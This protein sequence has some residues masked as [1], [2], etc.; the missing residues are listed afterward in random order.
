MGEG[1]AETNNLKIYEIKSIFLQVYLMYIK[2]YCWI[3]GFIILIFLNN[4][5][6]LMSIEAFAKMNL[7]TRQVFS[8]LLVRA[9]YQLF[10]SLLFRSFWSVFG[11]PWHRY[12]LSI[13]LGRWVNCKI[14]ISLYIQN[15]FSRS[16]QNYFTLPYKLYII[17]F[18]A[19]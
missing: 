15:I 11:V 4:I 10:S 5:W 17:L 9:S 19:R 12:H 18:D 6:K 16:A 8:K 14:G 7:K 2:K 1:S 3:K 13:F